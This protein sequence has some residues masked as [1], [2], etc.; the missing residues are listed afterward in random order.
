MFEEDCQD[1]IIVEAI[2]KRDVKAAC[3]IAESTQHNHQ[4]TQPVI[5]AFVKSYCRFF[6]VSDEIEA[7]IRN[8]AIAWQEQQAS[9]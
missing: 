5:L 2:N 9:A 4:H 6:N 8:F 1:S 3:E 7:H